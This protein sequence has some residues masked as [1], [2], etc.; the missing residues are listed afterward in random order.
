MQVFLVAKLLILLLAANGTPVVAKRL[1]GKRFAWPIDGGARFWDGQ[2]VFGRSKTLRG[3]FSSILVTAL[4]APLLGLPWQIGAIVSASAMA[5]D[6]FSSFVKRRL[7][8]PSSSRASGL[9]QIP[10]SLLPFLVCRPLL[11]LSAAD[12][13]VGVVAFFVGE[14]VM[15]RLLYRLGVRDRPY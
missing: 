14:I 3:L 7:H 5:G 13:A 2:P 6:L 11:S 10:E 1:F 8:W 4:C 9:D 12:I 15:S